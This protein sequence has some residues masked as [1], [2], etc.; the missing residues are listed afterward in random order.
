MTKFF[1]FKKVMAAQNCLLYGC[2]NLLFEIGKKFA[3][4]LFP[5][6]KDFEEIIMEVNNLI[7]TDWTVELTEMSE[8]SYTVNVENCIFCTETGVSCDL[9]EGF[10]VH[11]LQKTL[12]SDKFVAFE[13]KRKNVFDPKHKNFTIKLR[14]ENLKT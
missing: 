5:F 9:F 11:S 1:A 4:Y 2:D 3:F 12:P 13:G 8:E 14:I 10:L 7:Q 6:G